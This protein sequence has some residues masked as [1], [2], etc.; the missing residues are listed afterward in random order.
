M[1]FA[2]LKH[3]VYW[4]RSLGAPLAALEG[5]LTAVRRIKAR[6]CASTDPGSV[7]RPDSDGSAVYLA[8]VAAES[9]LCDHTE[10]LTGES[11]VQ[12][13]RLY[14]CV[15]VCLMSTLSVMCTYVLTAYPLLPTEE[16]S[17]SGQGL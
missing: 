8:L 11:R 17:A 3:R 16:G 14:V 4:R 1:A 12:S 2:S 6:P 9:G 5:S 10:T 15:Y 13:S 7:A